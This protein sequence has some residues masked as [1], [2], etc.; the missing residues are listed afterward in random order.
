MPDDP[1]L[2]LTN[3][4]LKDFYIENL[5]GFIHLFSIVEDGVKS[6][7]AEPLA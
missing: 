7:L 3:E 2:N 1:L 4:Q 5:G 6:W